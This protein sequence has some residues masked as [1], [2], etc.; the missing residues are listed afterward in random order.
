MKKKIAAIFLLAAFLLSIFPF[1]AQ[2]LYLGDMDADNTLTAG[3]ARIIL[4]ACVGLETLD[5]ESLIVADIDGNGK[6]TSADAR[7]ALRM[8]VGLQAPVN[9]DSLNDYKGYRRNV[10]APVV[11]PS[12]MYTYDMLC[13]DLDALK[14]VYPSLFSYK[15]L[16]KTADGRD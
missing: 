2:A 16:C 3:D 8:S 14:S 6:I 15:S 9:D 11:N 5:A 12:V 10:A 4:R 7:L 1:C 13:S